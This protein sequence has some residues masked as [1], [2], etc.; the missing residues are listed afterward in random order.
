MKWYREKL[1]KAGRLDLALIA[2]QYDILD[3]EKILQK[4]LVNSGFKIAVDGILG[5]QTL[6]ALLKVKRNTFYKELNALEK[7]FKKS[8]TLR[9]E[10]RKSLKETILQYLAVEEG[11]MFHWNR[12]ENS[13]T[14]PYG[15]YKSANRNEEIIIY[16]DSL[17]EKYGLPQTK[18]GSKKLNKKLNS[19]ERRKIADMAFDLYYRKYMSHKANKTLDHKGI[20]DFG[21]KDAYTKLKLSIFS[22][23]VNAGKKKAIFKLQ[24]TVKVFPDGLYGPKTSQAVMNY[25]AT[26]KQFNERYLINVKKFYDALINN[27]YERYGIFQRGW[28][29][30]LRRLGLKIV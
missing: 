29:N 24:Q 30:R 4:A 2:E 9:K 26:P 6:N 21:N 15:I 3:K 5:V 17:F 16:S 8:K 1:K 28:Y 14:T 20:R 7:D 19:L 12:K 25:T 22:L 11:T 18:Q 23:S 10:I 27:N 13:Y